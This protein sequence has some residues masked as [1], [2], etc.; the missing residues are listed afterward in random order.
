VPLD[1]N[2]LVSDLLP[3]AQRG[4][5][6]LHVVRLPAQRGRGRGQGQGGLLEGRAGRVGDWVGGCQASGWRAARNRLALLGCDTVGYHTTR[7]PPTVTA[8]LSPP[9]LLTS[10]NRA[11]TW[12]QEMRLRMR[13]KG[14]GI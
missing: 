13:S 7:L 6:A 3:G 2:L 4:L 14:G 9:H 10:W 5:A 12:L 8:T 1:P 11:L